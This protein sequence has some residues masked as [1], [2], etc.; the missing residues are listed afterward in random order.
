[1]NIPEESTRSGS[2]AA[3]AVPDE[4]A[5]RLQAAF[6]SLPEL[7]RR[8]LM[9]WRVDGLDYE[10]IARITGTSL[11]TAKLQLWRARESLRVALAGFL[12]D[13]GPRAAAMA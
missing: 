2:G 3:A 1:M 9:L 7:Q 13:G 11:R 12:G 10:E 4:R 5:R 8:I 6:A